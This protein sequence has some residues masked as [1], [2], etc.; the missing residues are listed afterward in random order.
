MLSAAKQ[1]DA[2]SSLPFDNNLLDRLMD[3]A[4][5][6]V[7]LTTSKHNV[8]YLLGGHRTFF[9]DHMDALGP[10]RYLPVLA[11]PKGAP[12]QASYAGHGTEGFQHALNPFWTPEVCT[13]SAGS[14]DSMQKT[15]D[16][17]R[18]LGLKPKRIGVELPFLPA[19]AA[20]LLQK[21]F[22]DA[23]IVDS[24][25]VLERLR[26]RKTP[27]ELQKLR[28]AT[29]IVVDS[30]LAVIDGHG[31]GVTK[32]EVVDA[33]RREETNRSLV[34]E[35]CLI[36]AGQSLNRAPS[37]QK[38]QAAE[39]MSFDSGGTYH[40]YI[41]DICRMAIQGEPDAELEDMLAE[42]ETIQRATMTAIKPGAIGAEVYEAG[43]K[44]TN[45]SKYTDHMDL[46]VHGVG[47]VSHESPRL[48]NRTRDPYKPEDARRPLESHMVLSVETTL[49]HPRRGFIKLEDTVA[50]TETG[51]E[52]YGDRAR[53][54][55]RAGAKVPRR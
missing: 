53:G 23:E 22:P 29:E 38:W 33:L 20:M 28:L 17:L 55:N 30:M 9:F 25:L 54:W 31:P 13:K 8:Q 44:V 43:L 50:V 26:A 48:T 1:S 21:S 10:S 27:E 3:E 16:H 7:A 42:I 2:A 19:D 46:L 18:K 45:K 35:Y 52:V 32:Q 14:T 40:G 6:D 39:I 47:L 49:K 4:R 15:I 51:H 36:T 41:G 34:F 12:E 5:I 24:L 11:Y 37:P